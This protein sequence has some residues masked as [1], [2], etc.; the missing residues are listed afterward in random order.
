MP[1]VKKSYILIF[2]CF[3]V[4]LAAGIFYFRYQKLNR[5]ESKYEVHEEKLKFNETLEDEGLLLTF[6]KPRVK[7]VYDK[8]FQ[9]DVYQ[10]QIPFE[11]QNV[12]KETFYLQEKIGENLILVTGGRRWVTNPIE[13]NGEKTKLTLKKG[14]K[15]AGQLQFDVVPE[16]EVKKKYYSSYKLYY[17]MKQENGE[18]KYHL[19][20]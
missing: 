3:C 10:Y 20:E 5:A 2:C 17:L 18:F 11:A 4:V 1:R 15:T 12:S 6:S 14:E 19:S 16:S 8:D 9:S 7:T 13:S